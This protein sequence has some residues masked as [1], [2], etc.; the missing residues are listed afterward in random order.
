MLEKKLEK[1][2]IRG[3][4]QSWSYLTPARAMEEKGA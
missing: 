3:V 1:E 2:G 4:T